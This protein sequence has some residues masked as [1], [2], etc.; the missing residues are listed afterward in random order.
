M[1]FGQEFLMLFKTHAIGCTHDSVSAVAEWSRY[2][3]VACLWTS[4][5]PLKTHRV[6]QRCTLNLSRAEISYHW[7]GVVVR[8]WGDSS[9]V[10][11]VTLP[12]F[13]ITCSVAKIPRVAKQCDV[14]IH[15][16]TH[17]SLLIRTSKL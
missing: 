14:N 7:C 2:R 10:V 8:S 17:S 6:G 9:C 3:I 1:S 5:V 11:H 4:P 16:L 15:S 13:E 12:W